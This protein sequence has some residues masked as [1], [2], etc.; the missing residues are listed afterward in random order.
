MANKYSENG[1][2]TYIRGIIKESYPDM[3]VTSGF[4]P[5]P[6]QA[7]AV[8]IHEMD[9]YRPRR[10]VTLDN[11]DEQYQVAFQAD[12]Y[13]NLFNGSGEEAY[14]IMKVVETAFRQLYFIE[15]SCTTVERVN[16]RVTRLAAR[17]E[18][19]I[20]MGNEMPEV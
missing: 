5:I 13:S 3:Y 6:P 9:H 12:V 1:I 18:R 17:F 14:D 8:R 15:T 20:G 10:N 16:N 19:R 4:E 7:P 11:L 2:Y